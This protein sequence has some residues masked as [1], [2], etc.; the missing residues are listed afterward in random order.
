VAVSDAEGGVL[1][2]I[3]TPGKLSVDPDCRF[4]AIIWSVEWEMDKG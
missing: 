1:K 4:E 3:L 2:V